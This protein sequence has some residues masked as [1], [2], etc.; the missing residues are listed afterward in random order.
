MPLPAAASSTTATNKPRIRSRRRSVPPPCTNRDTFTPIRRATI[1]SLSSVLK[2]SQEEALTNR[3]RRVYFFD[4]NLPTIKPQQILAPAERVH[5]EIE[6]PEQLVVQSSTLR[7]Q[8]EDSPPSSFSS[9]ATLVTNSICVQPQSHLDA[10]E[11]SIAESESSS[12]RS[13]LSIRL[14]KMNNPFLA[15]ARRG[16][17]TPEATNSPVPSTSSLRKFY[18][19]CP[20]KIL[21]K[22]TSQ[23][24]MR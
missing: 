21:L 13:S 24:Q 10:R 4:S 20:R 18:R 22:V 14:P 1:P 11:E 15:K 12:R 6:V 8:L 17:G 7:P 3:H 16:A 9:S 5:N 19:V 2:F 23:F